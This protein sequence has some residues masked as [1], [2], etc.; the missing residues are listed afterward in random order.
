MPG[1]ISKYALQDECVETE[2]IK[3]L[4][5]TAAKLAD[6]A[7]LV[8]KIDSTLLSYFLPFCEIDIG[9]IDYSLIE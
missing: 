1:W 6:N 7:V 9:E 2:A 8:D 5:V 4:T 3:D